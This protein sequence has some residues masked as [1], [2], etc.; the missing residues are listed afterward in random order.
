MKY[1]RRQPLDVLTIGSATRDIFVASSHFEKLVSATAPDGFSACLPMGSKISVDLMEQASGGGATNGAVTFARFG[2]RTACL[3]RIG[4]DTAGEDVV[5]EIAREGVDISHM[6]WDAKEKTASS[7]IFLSGHGSR[8]VLVS[9]GASQHIETSV[10]KKGI[11]ANWLYLTSLGG[12]MTQL[13]EV[14]AAAKK[15]GTHIAWNPGNGE[16][17]YGYKVLEPFLKQTDILLLNREEAADLAHVAPRMLEEMQLLLSPIPKLALV[18]TDGARGA[19]A[20][21]RGVVWHVGTIKGKRINTT[22]AGDAFNSGFVASLIKE[23]DIFRALHIAAL[24]AFGVV[25]HMGA[26]RGILKHYP[27]ASELN[28]VKVREISRL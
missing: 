6:Q 5:R 22:G 1:V 26:K 25:T 19:Y 8:C 15:S 4:S 23:G 18:I 13:K 7:I 11:P 10:L 3:S 16:L 17:E 28:L 2:L 9:R 20:F 12:K 14:F 27:K 24:N 21:S